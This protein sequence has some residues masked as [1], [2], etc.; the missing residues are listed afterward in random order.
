MVAHQFINVNIHLNLI[1]DIA[2][3]CYVNMT[4]SYAKHSCQR[5]R[6]TKH[7]ILVEIGSFQFVIV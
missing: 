4:L 6:H 2:N 7:I 1:V 3:H 5:R